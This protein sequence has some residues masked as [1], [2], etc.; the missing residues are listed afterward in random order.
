MET[1][2][3]WKHPTLANPSESS[4]CILGGNVSASQK[5]NLSMYISILFPDLK[6]TGVF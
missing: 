5:I 4:I 3:S 2:Y 6:K 1:G